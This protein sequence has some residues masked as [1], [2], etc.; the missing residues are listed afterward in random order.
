MI[1]LRNAREDEAS[2]LAEIGVRSWQKAMEAIG[3]ADA[4]RDSALSAF[5]AFTSSRWLTITV[6]EWDGT[7]AGWAARENLD[8]KITDFWIEPAAA[9]RGLGKALL[10]DVEREMVMQGLDRAIVVTHAANEEAI[11]FFGH[12]G[13]HLDWLSLDYSPKLDREVDSIGLSKLFVAPVAGPYGAF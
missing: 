6:V 13:Y 7:A 8:E 1:T 4:L 12:L 5:R 10:A 9:G 3:G 2:L 11:G